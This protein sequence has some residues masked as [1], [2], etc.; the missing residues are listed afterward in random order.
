MYAHPYTQITKQNNFLHNYYLWK[1]LE[2][3][4]KKI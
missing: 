2:V 1:Y 3:L 4:S